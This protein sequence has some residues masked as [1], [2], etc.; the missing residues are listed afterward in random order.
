MSD[1]FVVQPDADSKVS[2]PVFSAAQIFSE[3]RVG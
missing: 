2:E 3:P 1:R